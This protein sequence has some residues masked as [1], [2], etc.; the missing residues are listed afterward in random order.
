MNHT[1]IREDKNIYIHKIL[2]CETFSVTEIYN[3][4][5]WHQ[6]KV[7]WQVCRETAEESQLSFWGSKTSKKKKKKNPQRLVKS[8][9]ES[10]TA[11][12][13][14]IWWTGHWDFQQIGQL[15]NWFFARQADCPS[16]CTQVLGEAGRPLCR[17]A[18]YVG[19]QPG[20][21]RVCAD[22]ICASCEAQLWT[23]QSWS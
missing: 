23:A 19:T 22:R 14:I 8:S 15:L 4:Q 18:K 6:N 16:V 5:N 17:L 3:I 21:H 2:R 13:S 9:Q 12:N 7:D 10:W 20:L 11:I 1:Q